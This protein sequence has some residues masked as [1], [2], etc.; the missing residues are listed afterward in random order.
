MQCAIEYYYAYLVKHQNLDCYIL[1]SIVRTF[2]KENDS[3][4]LPLHYTWTVTEKGL[5]IKWAMWC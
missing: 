2:F 4:I 5:K 3:E 1:L